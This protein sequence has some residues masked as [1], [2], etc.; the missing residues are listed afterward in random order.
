MH[1]TCLWPQRELVTNPGL[2]STGGF[3]APS[4]VF[5][6][7]MTSVIVKAQCSCQH[8]Y[9]LLVFKDSQHEVTST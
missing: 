9:V 8:P 7:L 5:R 1:I 4:A 3:L 6:L 2:Q